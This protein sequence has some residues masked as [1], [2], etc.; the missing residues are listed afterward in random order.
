MTIKKDTP[1]GKALVFDNESFFVELRARLE[2]GHRITLLARGWSMLPLIWEGRDTM[3]LAPLTPESISVG[4]VVL[5]Q[6]GDRRYVIHRIEAIREGRVTLRGD[7]NPYQR[8]L[9]HRSQV[10]AELVEIER[11]SRYVRLDGWGAKL[12]HRLWPSTPLL[13]RGLLFLYRRLV[14][15]RKVGRPKPR[16]RT[17]QP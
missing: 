13:R 3:T 14:V 15:W 4:R 1:Q 16:Q 11:A 5:A 17:A 12:Y 10:L 9:C 7:G 6:L 2:E 8:E